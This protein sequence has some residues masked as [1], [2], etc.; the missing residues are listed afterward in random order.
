[1]KTDGCGRRGWLNRPGAGGAGAWGW[2]RLAGVLA[3]AGAGCAAPGPADPYPAT[4]SGRGGTSSSLD[5]AR[6]CLRRAVVYP[7]NPVVRAAAVEAMAGA[8]D[9]ALCPRIRLALLDEHPG[10]RFAACAAVGDLKDESAGAA[11][12][13]LLDDPDASVRAAALYARHRLGHRER[14]GELVDLL[15][16]HSDSLVRCNAAMLLGRLGEPSAVQPL[17]RAMRDKDPRVQDFALEA[18]A[19]L[20]VEEA[21]SQL[22]YMAHSGIGSQEAFAVGA[23]GTTRNPTDAELLR[24]KLGNASHL[25]TRLAAARA[26]GRLGKRDGL[27][28]AVKGLSFNRPRREE[29]EDAPEAQRVRI[30]AMA[31]AALGDIGDPA[32]LPALARIL[33]R[34]EDPR[35]QVAA[36]GAILKISREAPPL[37]SAPPS[38]QRAKP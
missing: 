17:A 31:A 7:D 10:V 3:A 14:S 9:Q 28:L 37:F 26:L 18:L 22:H 30:R 34:G 6:E 16:T 1:M 35:L 32:A 12:R 38:A 25:E 11:A 23:L 36:A 2:V 4:L 15:L 20:G 24:E 33:E 21:R 13:K 27:D 5:L 8:E 29:A 19:A